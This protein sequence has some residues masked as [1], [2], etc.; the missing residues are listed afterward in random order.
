[1]TGI[2][3]DT[4]SLRT[5]AAAVDQVASALASMRGAPGDPGACGFP[6]LVDAVQRA[7][8]RLDESLVRVQGGYAHVGSEL[9]AS[10]D[11]YRARDEAVGEALTAI[12]RGLDSVVVR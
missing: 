3:V 7:V 9:R 1:M 12:G 6:V 4:Q 2:D 11:A 8:G 5:A 10:A